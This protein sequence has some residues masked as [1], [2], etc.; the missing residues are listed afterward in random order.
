MVSYSQQLAV[1]GWT[2]GI[3]HTDGRVALGTFSDASGQQWHALLIIA[4]SF[5]H[6]ASRRNNNLRLTRFPTDSD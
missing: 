6:P 2:A 1:A 3:S 5:E 4:T